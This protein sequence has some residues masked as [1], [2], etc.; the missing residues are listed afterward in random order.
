MASRWNS[1]LTPLRQKSVEASRYD[2]IL[3]R[4]STGSL[5]AD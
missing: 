3:L 5:Q 1:L 4:I 2:R